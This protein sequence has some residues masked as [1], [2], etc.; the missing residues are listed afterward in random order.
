LTEYYPIFATLR[1]V[2]LAGKN[3][4]LFPDRNLVKNRT[5]GD[6]N[7]P[8]NGQARLSVNAL[9]ASSKFDFEVTT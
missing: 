7:H 5:K 2:S 4:V 9:G 1:K 6:T 8:Q 3:S